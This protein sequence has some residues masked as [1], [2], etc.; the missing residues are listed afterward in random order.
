MKK[1]TILSLVALFVIT[2]PTVAY[3][4]CDCKKMK[5]KDNL[6]EKVFK[7]AHMIMKNR[8]ELK[9]SESQITEIKKLKVNAKKDL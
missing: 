9:L 2:I 6:E 5:H 8:D 3:T 4:D 7:K 1:F